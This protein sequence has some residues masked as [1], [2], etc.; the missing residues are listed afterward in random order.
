MHTQL[1]ARPLIASDGAFK[2]D[3]V[4]LTQPQL[5]ELLVATT[6]IP[7]LRYRYTGGTQT[8]IGPYAQDYTDGATTV[9][10]WNSVWPA[11]QPAWPCLVDL[12]DMCGTLMGCVQALSGA[13]GTTRAD[14]VQLQADVAYVTDQQEQTAQLAYNTS[15]VV[16]YMNA[17]LNLDVFPVPDAG[18][19]LRWDPGHAY[20]TPQNVTIATCSDVKL[21]GLQN[22]ELLSYDSVQSKWVNTAPVALP[23][24]VTAERLGL[25]ESDIGQ[26]AAPSASVVLNANESACVTYGFNATPA[27]AEGATQR[28]TATD[29]TYPFAALVRDTEWAIPPVQVT[30]TV[31]S[32]NP[33]PPTRLPLDDGGALQQQLYSNGGYARVNYDLGAEY[34]L[35][36]AQSVV[37]WWGAGLSFGEYRLY[38]CTSA[39]CMTDSSVLDPPGAAY[40]LLHT[41]TG[42]AG[43]GPRTVYG[44]ASSTGPW[45][46]VCLI[47]SGGHGSS[48]NLRV[49]VKS[50]PSGMTAQSLLNGDIALSRNSTT[51]GLP[52][53]T[54]T[55]GSSETLVTNCQRLG[56]WLLWRDLLTTVLARGTLRVGGWRLEPG[57]DT[58]ELALTN[59]GYD[60]STLSAG[61]PTTGFTVR[62]STQRGGDWIVLR[63]S[64]TTGMCLALSTTATFP[65]D[66]G[67]ILTPNNASGTSPVCITVELGGTIRSV[68]AVV[69]NDA[70]LGSFDPRA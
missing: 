22:G 5:D 65:G 16:N 63:P 19:A 62:A 21:T 66:I 6:A 68:N 35:A 67:F 11:Q 7:V 69:Q 4:Q 60:Q 26:L 12:G 1:E 61:T 38:G 40:T 3:V 18:A 41:A 54:N 57:A 43:D 37:W 46:Y 15:E 28:S 44:T 14:I 58:R 17:R 51:S 30:I 52:V 34:V 29:A 48:N 39:T 47:F 33:T 25:I 49:L 27:A 36:T 70:G 2:T 24:G 56:Q 55:A 31:G 9:P 20:F 32:S 42:T 10:G 50:A 45:R 8:H 64:G 59:D 23:A 13:Q 53:V